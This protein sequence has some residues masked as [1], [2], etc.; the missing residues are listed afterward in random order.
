MLNLQFT[1]IRNKNLVKNCVYNARTDTIRNGINQF[2]RDNLKSDVEPIYL[3]IDMFLRVSNNFVYK[4]HADGQS[5]HIK[6][7]CYKKGNWKRKVISISVR[8]V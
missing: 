7:S 6:L 2:L 8:K 3:E 4:K 1:T 5:R